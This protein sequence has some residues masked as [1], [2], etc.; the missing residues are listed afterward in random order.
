LILIYGLHVA[1]K[2]NPG[3]PKSVAKQKS[4]FYTTK[5]RSVGCLRDFGATQHRQGQLLGLFSPAVYRAGNLSENLSVA[6][7]QK[8]GQA[9]ITP[10]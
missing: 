6:L 7:D 3:F 1:I 10:P 5:T 8:F 4:R 2:G 9:K